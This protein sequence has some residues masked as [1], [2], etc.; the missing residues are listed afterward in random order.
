MF[1]TS[2]FCRSNRVA[3][4]YN[5][6][7]Q[8]GIAAL[9]YLELSPPITTTLATTTQN[10]TAGGYVDQTTESWEN[11]IDLENLDYIFG[12]ENVDEIATTVAE[13]TTVAVPVG[14]LIN[15][16]SGKET[17]AL[18][19]TP[20]VTTTM[21]TTTESVTTN[22]PTTSPTTQ[23]TTFTS[24][25]VEETTMSSQF[26]SLATDDLLLNVTQSYVTG[27]GFSVGIDNESVWDTTEAFIPNSTTPRQA[28]VIRLT[29]PSQ[30]LEYLKQ[31]VHG[32]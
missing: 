6:A 9:Q 16:E 13:D 31:V 32:G 15:G 20:E 10:T 17:D 2:L 4:D 24:T 19:T 3:L 30:R 26:S 29:S 23:T 28:V 25:S 14:R 7:F 8:S 21:E 11:E 27:G 12:L 22:L 5:A 18:M 1:F